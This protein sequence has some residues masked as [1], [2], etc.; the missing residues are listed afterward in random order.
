MRTLHPL[1]QHLSRL[2]APLKNP[3]SDRVPNNLDL[4]PLGYGLSYDKDLAFRLANILIFG[5]QRIYVCLNLVNQILN[6]RFLKK[7]SLTINN[8]H[9]IKT[10]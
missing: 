10:C 8:Y 5:V 7:L 1:V 3:V 4:L 2:H 9:A 6:I